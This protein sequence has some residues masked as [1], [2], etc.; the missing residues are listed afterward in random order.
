M[1]L[2]IL[3]EYVNPWLVVYVYCGGEKN[4]LSFNESVIVIIV[5][6]YGDFYLVKKRKVLVV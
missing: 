5:R 3:K 2:W 4:G 1:H 6:I